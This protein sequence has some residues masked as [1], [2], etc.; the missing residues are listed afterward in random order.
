M[1]SYLP[2]ILFIVVGII[3]RILTSVRP[4]IQNWLFAFF[5]CLAAWILI[6][7]S[8]IQINNATQ[9]TNW[10]PFSNNS[11]AFAF[12]FDLTSW[13][14]LYC[15]VA[16]VFCAIWVSLFYA[17]YLLKR[18]FWSAVLFTTGLGALA[19]TANNVPA[20]VLVW[21][22]IDIAGLMLQPGTSN[23]P[24]AMI[25]TGSSFP[26]GMNLTGV[27]VL[28][29]VLIMDPASLSP[30]GSAQL[31]ST[32]EI[33]I[34]IA[35]LTRV[36]AITSRRESAQELVDQYYS[37]SIYK[38]VFLVASTVLLLRWDF[39]TM[40]ST[41]RVV[42]SIVFS[43]MILFNS[44]RWFLSGDQKEGRRFLIRFFFFTVFLLV[45]QADRL[46]AI[47]WMGNYL[48]NVGII[49]LGGY[50]FRKKLWLLILCLVAMSG[51]PFLPFSLAWQFNSQP[52]FFTIIQIL[53]LA[54]IFSGVL[55]LGKEQEATPDEM[56]KWINLFSLV[57]FFVL[58]ASQWLFL[59][60]IP[61]DVVDWSN[62]WASGT[63]LLLG[64]IAYVSYSVIARKKSNRIDADAQRIPKIVPLIK[65]MIDLKWSTKVVE[66][67]AK[68]LNSIVI[69]IT[70]ILEGEA[71]LIWSL[72][73]LTLLITIIQ[74]GRR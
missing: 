63:S 24:T 53:S 56:N 67:F 6:L 22:M 38:A 1:I 70:S 2:I 62:A 40:S 23:D 16:L 72:L 28:V 14:L 73:L 37:S 36:L 61:T 45:L 69:F 30:F 58:F 3:L 57:G 43:V 8:P 51:L 52:W 42:I 41:T 18:E 31:S 66:F 4:G 64:I 60:R 13:V 34:I 44:V 55:R 46:S 50:A 7:V 35:V 65:S 47:H 11:F 10:S 49:T 15:L 25:T 19:L 32:S 71:G 17:F 48:I 5:T 20:F 68:I 39:S 59:I 54:F 29:L 12:A 27:L 74:G 33:L 9:L 26:L 21:L